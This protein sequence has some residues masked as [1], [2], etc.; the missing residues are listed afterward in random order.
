M[1]NMPDEKKNTTN[2]NGNNVNQKSDS[3]FVDD[4]TTWRENCKRIGP[5]AL[6]VKHI[7]NLYM[8][9]KK[10]LDG[11]IRSGSR[12]KGRDGQGAI[13]ILDFLDGIVDNV[14][15]FTNGHVIIIESIAKDLADMEKTGEVAGDTGKALDPAFIL[16]SEPRYSDAGEKIEPKIRQGHYA[17]EWYAD[18]YE[19]VDKA[20]DEWFT[21]NNPPHDAL[22]SETGNDW[23]QPKGL[24]YIMREAAESIPKTENEVDV[25][26]YSSGTDATDID[27]L[28]AIED[29]FN[30][31]VRE[32]TY[33]NAGGRLL[34]NK[35]RKEL[36]STSFELSNKDQATIREIARLGS[37]KD[38]KGLAGVVT[39]FKLTATAT[40]I[41]TLTDRAL[42]RKNTNKAPN[43]YRAWQNS[44]KRGFDYR[45]TA[46]E[47]W[48]TSFTG[49][50]KP[51]YKPDQK[52]ISKLWQQILWR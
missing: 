14:D 39:T 42:K 24:L 23:A 18:R 8:M 50:K 49:D 43:G 16:F 2:F 27:N 10:H 40:P 17:S 47:K 28:S 31:V 25:G 36:Q 19:G 22:F 20:P 35:V 32:D 26:T 15:V 37:I 30:K 29:F 5:D 21:G 46:K 52:V 41:I 7:P 13:Q 4:Y 44:T 12:N 1:K 3:N 48:P 34:V 51:K 6:H 33:W 45:K 38:K 11:N 9:L